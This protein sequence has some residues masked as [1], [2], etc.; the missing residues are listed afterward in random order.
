[1]AKSYVN[2]FSLPFVLQNLQNVLSI[3]KIS[4]GQTFSHIEWNF[5]FSLDLVNV[6]ISELL[7]LQKSMFVIS[8]FTVFPSLL[9]VTAISW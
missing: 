9:T 1:M 4:H 2:V 5:L 3:S 8:L 6:A 7:L